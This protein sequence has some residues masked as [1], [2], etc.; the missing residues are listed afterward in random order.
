VNAASGAYAI[1]VLRWT[2]SVNEVELPE[3]LFDELAEP[4]APPVAEFVLVL[5]EFP[6]LFTVE[7]PLFFTADDPPVAVAEP[8][9]AVAAELPPAALEVLDE[10][11]FAVLVE[12][13]DE[14]CD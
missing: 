12:F 8:P 1:G 14:F 9:A 7:L 6:E 3:E 10:L 13:A 2:F 4:P 11:L 5:E